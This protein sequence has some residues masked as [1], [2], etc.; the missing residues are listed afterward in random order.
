MIDEL[1]IR[2][3][4]NAQQGRHIR[5]ATRD[6]AIG[7]N[8]RTKLGWF[9]DRL[10]SVRGRLLDVGCN[11]G[12][13][14][15]FLR[16]SGISPTGLQIIGVD[17][18]GEAV[19]AAVKRQIPG[20]TFQVSNVRSL[21]FPDSCFDAVSLMEVIEH[22]SEQQCALTEIARVLQPGGWLLFSTPNG[23]CEPWHRDE[24]LR[25]GLRRSLGMRVI[26]KDQPLSLEQIQHMVERCGFRFTEGPEYYWY[27]PY[28]VFK[29]VLWWPPRYATKGL[30][31]AMQDCLSIQSESISPGDARRNMQTIVGVARKE[32]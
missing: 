16:Q 19:A 30:R 28:R 20:A 23:D 13:L 18:A 22:L 24:N 14:A 31:R 26:D 6:D 5:A 4:F 8:Y 7:F 1:R 29:G 11:I 27:R 21:P 2:E 3:Y 15:W 17:I 12:N 9:A 32:R 10:R 25:L